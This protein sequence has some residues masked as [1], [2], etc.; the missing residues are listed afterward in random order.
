IEGETVR[1]SGPAL[2]RRWMNSLGLRE[3]G[4]GRG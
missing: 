3:A 2:M 4:R 1:L